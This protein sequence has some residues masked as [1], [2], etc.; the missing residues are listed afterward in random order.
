MPAASEPVA[1][2]SLPRTWHPVGIRIAVVFFGLTLVAVSAGAWF[3]FDADVRAR[4]TFLQRATLVFFGLAM[5]FLGWLLWRCRATAE[6]E[7][8]V[9]VNGLRRRVFAWEEILAVHL[10]PGAPWAT[11]DLADGTTVSVLG[12]QGSDGDRAQRGVRELRA[13]LDRRPNG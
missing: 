2:P 8:L 3:G 1:L 13:L 9:V 10:P 4:F 7:G 11:L 12:L 6:M 5:A